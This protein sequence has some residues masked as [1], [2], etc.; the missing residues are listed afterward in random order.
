MYNFDMVR[1]G[2]NSF[3]K[4][5]SLTMNVQRRLAKSMLSRAKRR[6]AVL[7]APSRP[8]ESAMGQGIFERNKQLTGE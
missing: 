1:A 6:F 7:D 8:E 2:D 3:Y 4:D 5:N